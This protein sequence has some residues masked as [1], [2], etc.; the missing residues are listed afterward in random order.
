MVDENSARGHA[1]VL[2]VEDQ[3][4]MRETLRGFLQHAFPGCSFHEAE[5]GASAL[6]ACTALRPDLVLMDKCLPDADG[7]ELTARLTTMYPGIQV[8]VI[9]QRSGEIYVQRALAA[10]ACAYLVKDSLGVE[11]FPAVAAAIGIAPA[12]DTGIS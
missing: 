8:I 2:I 12:T 7:I 9:S 5:D 3:T 11:L 4:L 6:D 10:G 1:T